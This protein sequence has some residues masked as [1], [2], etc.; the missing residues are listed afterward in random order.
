MPICNE[1]LGF[2]PEPDAITRSNLW[3]LLGESDYSLNVGLMQIIFGQS[4]EV[5][6]LKYDPILFNTAPTEKWGL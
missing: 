4:T 3:E 6:I 5:E 1:L 2:K